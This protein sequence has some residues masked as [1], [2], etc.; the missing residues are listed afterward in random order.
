MRRGRK[1]K[2][3]GQ[4]QQQSFVALM[5]SRGT[6]ANRHYRLQR[7]LGANDKQVPDPSCS[8]YGASIIHACYVAALLLL[9]YSRHG[10]AKLV[11]LKARQGI[12]AITIAHNVAVL[13]PRNS[14][15]PTSHFTQ[16]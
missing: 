6:G 14:W 15:D 5:R 13:G 4:A 10:A 2:K 9:L 7:C 3:A 8:I 16:L 1:E 12:L 11:S